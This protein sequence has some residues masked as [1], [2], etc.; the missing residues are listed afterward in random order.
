MKAV[1]FFANHYVH[2][3]KHLSSNNSWVIRGSREWSH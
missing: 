3:D 2:I 1:I